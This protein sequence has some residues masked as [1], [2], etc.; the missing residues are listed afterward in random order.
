MSDTYADLQKTYP[1]DNLSG[2]ST[3]LYGCLKQI[4]LIKAKHRNLKNILSIGGWT[5]SPNF[6]SPMSS[7]NGRSMFASSALALVKDL[8]FDG[9]DIDW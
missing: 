8:G 2:P 3:D 6:P 1:G 4:L 7:S 9:I 5:Y